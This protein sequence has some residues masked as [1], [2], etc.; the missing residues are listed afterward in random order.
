MW[1]KSF[2]QMKK[3]VGLGLLRVWR[4]QALHDKQFNTR[5]GEKKQKKQR[6]I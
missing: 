1:E 6:D 2:S 3:N 5:A 4:I